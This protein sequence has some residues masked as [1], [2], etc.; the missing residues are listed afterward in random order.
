[1]RFGQV[2]KRKPNP[3][4]KRV[5][6]KMCGKKFNTIAGFVYCDDCAFKLT[7]GGCLWI[8][9]VVVV[10]GLRMVFAPET[11]CLFY[12]MIIVVSLSGFGLA[13][14]GK[15]ESEKFDYFFG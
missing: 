4:I 9:I 3:N 1:M 5:E 14:V 11:E 6:C 8:L 7:L 2:V 15:I 12:L 13:G 10:S